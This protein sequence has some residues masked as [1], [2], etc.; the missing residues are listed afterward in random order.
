MKLE[1]AKGMSVF[2][3]KLLCLLERIAIALEKIV[4]N[5]N[6]HLT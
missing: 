3:V 5:D 1:E 6:E 2:C 4:E